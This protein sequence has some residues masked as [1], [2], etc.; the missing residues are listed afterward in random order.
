MC[1][2]FLKLNVVTPPAS[3]HLRLIGIE[4]CGLSAGQSGGFAVL[5]GQDFWLE[6]V[7]NLRFDRITPGRDDGAQDHYETADP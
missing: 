3:P 7:C 1:R 5:C 6:H 2:N 4:R